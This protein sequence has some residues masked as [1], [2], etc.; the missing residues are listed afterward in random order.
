[1]LL[2]VSLIVLLLLLRQPLLLLGQLAYFLA[3]RCLLLD[4]ESYPAFHSIIAHKAYLPRYRICTAIG[5]G[6][7][8]HKS[9]AKSVCKTL[10]ACTRRRR[11]KWPSEAARKAALN[12]PSP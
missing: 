9:L 3:E 10:P 4:N 11:A 12:A 7:A 5:T 1:M 6:S 8:I 2:R